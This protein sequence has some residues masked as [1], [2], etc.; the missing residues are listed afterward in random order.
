MKTLR[1]VTIDAV[2]LLQ[3]PEPSGVVLVG[4]GKQL[5][6]QGFL[7]AAAASASTL[8]R[9]LFGLDRVFDLLQLLRAFVDLPFGL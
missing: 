5:V 9:R 7:P 6:R 2:R 4:F 1:R 3:I 8:Q